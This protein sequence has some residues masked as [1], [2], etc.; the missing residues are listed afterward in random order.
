MT[1]PDVLTMVRAS[2]QAD[3]Y[4]GLVNDT[5]GCGLDD[6]SPGGCMAQECQAAYKRTDEPPVDADVPM[7]FTVG[8]DVWY[9]PEKQP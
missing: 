4:D 7:S 6:L 1:T 5:C 9:S 3:G 8:R 2:L